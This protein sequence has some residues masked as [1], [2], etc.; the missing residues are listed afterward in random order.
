MTKKNKQVFGALYIRV[1]TDKQEELSPHAQKRLLLDYA[2]SHSISILEEHIYI[3]H[4]ISGRKAQKRPQFLK[5]IA[6]AKSKQHPFDVILVWKYSRFA[7][8]QEE[9]IVYKSLLRK[10]CN[11]EI[12]SISEPLIEGPFGSL[13]ERIIEWMDEYYS[14]RLSG[15]VQRG[16]ME[17]ALRGGYQSKLPLGY[18]SNGKIPIIVEHEAAIIQKIFH[19]YL[20]GKDITSIA[21]NLNDCGYKTNQGNPFDN[22]GIQYILDNP[23]YTGKVRWNYKNQTLSQDK[24]EVIISRGKHQ[25]IISDE[26]LEQVKKRRLF[27]Y[28]PMK[29]RS[30]STTKHWLTGLLKCGYCHSNLVYSAPKKRKS[31]GS[32]PFF[33]CHS[34]S[35]GKHSGSCAITE[36]KILSIL[37]LCFKEIEQ[38]PLISFTKTAICFSS[39]P[40]QLQQVQQAIKKIEHKKQ[41]ASTA[42]LDDIYTKQEFEEIKIA[43]DNEKNNLKQQEK[44]LTIS[45][46]QKEPHTIAC[47]ST[48][49]SPI[50]SNEEKN[51]V[52]RMLF[53]HIIF[54]RQF[55]LFELE[56]ALNL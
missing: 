37:L 21:R 32:S 14:I 53:T 12:L 4:G 27:E 9:S 47:I 29:Q 2:K 51:S 48:V 16:M 26:L 17:N 13:I 3:E 42:Y 33:Q 56:F 34:Y 50:F 31:G 43:L 28:T 18:Q 35:S 36:K 24:T 8:N 6:A 22:R 7:R 46:S 20:L 30:S 54:Y 52:F 39:I 23:F 40:L 25:A 15:E 55:S 44:S 10:Q 1:S 19:D 11:I 45:Q 5:M 38:I 41:R 49:L